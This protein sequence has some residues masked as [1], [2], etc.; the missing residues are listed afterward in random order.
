MDVNYIPLLKEIDFYLVT[1]RSES[2][3]FLM[4]YLE[5]YYRLDTQQAID[6]VCD[7]KGDKGVDGIYVNESLGSI[8]IFQSKITQSG[9]KQIGDVVLKEFTGTLSQFDNREKIEQLIA[10]A[11]RADVASLIN[12]L[13]LINKIDSYVIRG[14][15]VSNLNLSSDGEAYINKSG[16]EFIGKDILE[17]EYISDSKD[18]NTQV[19]AIFDISETQT[20]EYHVDG[21][22]KTFI[23]PIKALELVKLHGINDQ[24]IFDYN[25]RGSLGNTKINRGIVRSIKD[26]S[27]HK[28]FP[29]FHNG[30]TIV[31]NEVERDGDKLTLKK[32]YVVNGCQSLTSLYKHQ[33]FLTEELKV[34]TKI[35]QVPIDSPLSSQITEYSNS[36]NG[37][38]ARDFKSYNP[39]QV[40]IQNEFKSKYGTQYFFEIKRGES[41]LSQLETISNESTG[42]NLMS[43]DLKE[44]WGTHRKYQVFEEAYNEL[45]ARPEV[46]AD[47]ILFLHVLSK[48]IDN[49]I[50][51]IENKLI[52]RYSLMKYAIMYFTRSILEKDELGAILIQG[53]S[54]FVSTATLVTTLTAVLGQIL[55]DI[56]IDLNGEINELGDDFDYKSNLRDDNFVK[57]LNKAIV[58]SYLKQVNRGRVASFKQSWEKATAS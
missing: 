50:G 27:L 3:A 39:I 8:D 47:R 15:F 43:F 32:F 35:I 16:I 44:P 54:K 23:A 10:E 28:K 36:Q 55:D 45:F 37:V 29:L 25:V 14:I 46:T 31:A 9:A 12:R 30:I 13:D 38:K 21:Q 19:E 40:R 6:S 41:N 17:H 58:T 48:I 7:N 42:I 57:S 33:S 34:L 11:G 52:A 22:T 26:A 56:I 2:A 18:I 1:G 4:W 49:K 24:S 20:T 51:D 5:K 53:P